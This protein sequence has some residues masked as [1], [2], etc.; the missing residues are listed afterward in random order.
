MSRTWWM[1]VV[2]VVLSAVTG[3]G[4]AVTAPQQLVKSKCLVRVSQASLTEVV[5]HL[6]GTA[7]VAGKA[8]KE[9][10]G[11]GDCVMGYQV[12]STGVVQ[13]TAELPGQSASGASAFWRAV[14]DNLQK[15]MRQV[16]EQEVEEIQMQIDRA[17]RQKA[18]ALAILRPGPATS[19]ADQAVQEQLDK[20]VDLS[21]LKRD[22]SLEAAIDVM[23]ESVN[24]A[25]KVTVVWQDLS[26]KCLTDPVTPIGLDGVNPMKLETGLR[27]LLKL[28]SD[29]GT[30]GESA[31]EYAMDGGV[32]IIAT[33]HTL[34]SLVKGAAEGPGPQL[35]AEELANRRQGLTNQLQEAEMDSLRLQARRRA[36]EQQATE[37]K[38]RIDM[39]L[40]QDT[41]IR[42]LQKLVDTMAQ[43]QARVQSL[44]EQGAGAAGADG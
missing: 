21:A 15:A 43:G 2:W 17:E 40:D 31:V 33:K 32:V 14:G 44:I 38:K 12:V 13:L 35:S 4:Q 6:A 7:D 1:C 11:L 18:E 30:G 5:G 34:K 27:L 16:N 8:A 25:L 28:V 3:M 26:D 23:K 24:P 9:V 29:R 42:E 10:F 19:R 39:A 20:R 22:M 37:L 36:I 41:L